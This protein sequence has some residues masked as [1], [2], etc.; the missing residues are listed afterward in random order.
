MKTITLECLRGVEAPARVA[1]TPQN[2]RCQAY[3]QVTSPRPLA[4][5]CR[6]RPVEELPRLVTLA[7][8]AH[9]L[10]AALALDRLG[11]VT[12]PEMAQNMREG[13]RLALTY[14]HHLRKLYFLL[15]AW[16]N[17]W[18]NGDSLKSRR[19][20]HTFPPRLMDDAWR[21]LSLAQEAVAILGGRFD[22][23]VTAVAGG[24]SRF[25]KEEHYARLAVI[26]GA[27]RDFAL[28][29]SEFLASQVF[30]WGREEG[31]LA[32]ELPPLPS[33]TLSTPEE[34]F[35]R[36]DGQGQE[37]ERF[38]AAA[39][40]E[41]VGRQQE[42]WTYEAFA[43]FRE[44]GWQHLDPSAVDH[45]FAVGPLPRLN[46]GIAASTPAAVGEVERL[47]SVL[48]PLPRRELAA[49]YWA[50][51]V[52]LLQAAELMVELYTPE[53]LTGPTL[54][55]I[56]AGWGREAQAAVESPAGWLFI[57]VR[58]DERGLIEDLQLLDPATA[59]NAL[60]CLVAQQVVAA[61]AAANLGWQDTKKR[62]E[63]SLLPL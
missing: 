16:E 36:R 27:C 28:S 3:F 44:Q 25:L 45:L 57:Q 49:A 48:G 35:V 10:A 17:P 37:Q 31:W 24:V 11:Q 14:R 56:P 12:P 39:L 19:R 13:L 52:D 62:L 43:Y 29:F 58:V 50:L 42:P 54:R 38:A 41:K 30:L 6:Q 21:H 60:R 33:L 18:V 47:C 2:G 20:P 7:S 22:H 63:L 55:H 15:L 9:H 23:P 34:Q 8:P 1:I 4:Q 51:L 61:A 59:N 26:A 5:L 40:W 53:K 46:S 32:A